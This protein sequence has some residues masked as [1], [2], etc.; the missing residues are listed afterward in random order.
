M[1]SLTID[2]FF[3]QN[4]KGD[5]KDVSEYACLRSKNMCCE[6]GLF[7]S[8]S[9]YK[10]LDGVTYTARINLVYRFKRVVGNDLTLVASGGNLY[11]V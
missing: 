7:K 1:A 11:S 10:K 3:G 5:K 9:G 8:R 4:T 6:Q 2:K